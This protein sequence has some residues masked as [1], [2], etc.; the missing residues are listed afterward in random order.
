MSNG[1][2]KQAFRERGI[3]LN[4][5]WV[6]AVVRHRAAQGQSMQPQMNDVMPFFLASDIRASTTNEGAA[7]VSVADEHGKTL[8]GF[9]LVQVVRVEEIGKSIISQIEYLNQWEE[10]KRLKGQ[11]IIRLV[12]EGNEEEDKDTTDLDDSGVG[13]AQ[14][15]LK[16]AKE[17]KSICKVILEDAQ[18]QRFYGLEIKPVHG[19]WLGMALGTKMLITNARIHRGVCLLTP[20]STRILGGEIALWNNDYFPTKLREELK[21]KLQTSHK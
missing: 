5:A 8:T 17:F 3:Y 18:G 11:Q 19:I 16:G 9:T 12:H 10:R 21:A 2:L 20:A 13:E 14:D 15:A 4:E 7:S 6:Q 1:L